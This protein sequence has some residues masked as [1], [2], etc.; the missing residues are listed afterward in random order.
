M[1]NWRGTSLYTT[2]A[3]M[4]SRVS[5]RPLMMGGTPRSPRRGRPWRGRRSRAWARNTPNWAWNDC[6]SPLKSLEVTSQ[7][8]LSSPLTWP[9]CQVSS[10]NWAR[11][12][13]RGARAWRASSAAARLARCLSRSERW[14][15]W[16][17]SK[18]NTRR[19]ARL[20]SSIK[21]WVLEQSPWVTPTTVSTSGWARHQA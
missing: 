10:S 16:G 15:W 21:A 13:R 14:R 3:P 6:Q 9:V 2:A 19:P 20:K 8:W 4:A 5:C 7:S 18:A 17:Y 12:R 1:A 11:S